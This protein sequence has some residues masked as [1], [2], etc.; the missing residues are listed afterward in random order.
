MGRFED[1]QLFSHSPGMLRLCTTFSFS[2]WLARYVDEVSSGKLRISLIYALLWRD[3]QP[4]PT[5]R[6]LNRT[7]VLYT[8][9]KYRLRSRFEL[10][11][12]EFAT[13]RGAI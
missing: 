6:I 3:N 10:Q 13:Q 7:M 12:T 1:D 5:R 11:S 4:H 8:V 2:I 9:Y